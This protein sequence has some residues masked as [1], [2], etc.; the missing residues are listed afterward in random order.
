M[1]FD[2]AY[3]FVLKKL[4]NELP[5]SL[6]FHNAEH[7]KD[8]V[9]AVRHLASAEAFANGEATLLYTAAAFHDSG[10]LEVYDNHEEHSCKLARKYLPRFEY[11]PD[12]IEQVCSLIMATKIPQSPSTRMATILCDADLYYLGTDRYFQIAERLYKELMETG[13]I[14]TR[15][16]WKARQIEFLES[17]RYFTQTAQV[18]CNEGKEKN[19]KLLRAGS[20]KKRKPKSRKKREIGDYVSIILGAL[21]AGFGLKSFLVPNLF[22]DGGVTGVALIVHEIYNVDLALATIAI[23]LPLIGLGFYVVSHRFAY[24]TLFSILLLGI[25]LFFIQYPVVTSDKLLVAIFGGFFIGLGSGLVLRAGSAL[26]GSEILALHASRKTSFTISEFILIINVV[27]FGFAAFR[28]G[29]ET[30]LYSIL[31]YFTASRTIDYV[32]EGIEAYTG[33]TIVSGQSET[34][35]HRI[36]NEMGRAITIYKGERGFLPNNFELGKDCDIIF[37]VVSRLEV[38]RLKNLVFE[39]D[40]NAFVFANTIREAAGGILSRQHEH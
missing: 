17:H 39:T 24:K 3:S 33:V 27:I 10:F 28:F 23:N 7:T 19:L 9:Q 26:D 32:L 1:Q 8:V 6:T 36:L 37:I 15:E 5:K 21:A 14:N 38:R 12:Q 4:E 22:F 20:R 13:L 2:K 35:K 11:E 16:E 34:I 31:T 30:S 25:C 40:P 29:I 18:E